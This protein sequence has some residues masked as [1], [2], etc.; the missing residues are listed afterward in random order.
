MADDIRDDWDLLEVGPSP[1][2]HPRRWAHGVRMMCR[3]R[4]TKL[5]RV[6]SRARPVPSHRP[7]LPVVLVEKDGKNNE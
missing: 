5:K 1:D 2:S 6:L 3:Y 4:P 7:S